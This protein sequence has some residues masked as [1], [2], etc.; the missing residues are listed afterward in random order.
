MS[1]VFYVIFYVFT[2]ILTLYNVIEIDLFCDEMSKIEHMSH[3]FEN[4]IYE[5]NARQKTSPRSDK[6]ESL[7][8]KPHQCYELFGWHHLLIVSKVA[9]YY[10]HWLSTFE[11]VTTCIIYEDPGYRPTSS[12]VTCYQ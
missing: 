10:T 9:E 11:P 6:Y 4:R 2:A 1:K 7:S 3:R 5:Y 8:R 12:T